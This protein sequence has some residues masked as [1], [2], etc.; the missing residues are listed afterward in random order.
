MLYSN[1]LIISSMIYL[2]L[3]LHVISINNKSKT[4]KLFLLLCLSLFWS[5]FIFS[6]AY[7]ANNKTN[8]ELLFQFASCGLFFAISTILHFYICL[9]KC[10]KLNV[11]IIF[12]IHFPAI[13]LTFISLFS[14]KLLISNLNKVNYLWE[15]QANLTSFWT[16]FFLFYLASY[17]FLS[18][19]LLII[20][21]KNTKSNKEKKQAIIG[22]SLLIVFIIGIS[23]AWILPS[24]SSYKSI[25]LTPFVSL[26]Y[27]IGIYIS[28]VKYRFL[29]I[30]PHLV[31]NEIISNVSEIILLLDQNHKIV[32]ANKSAKEVMSI[33]QNQIG[34]LH[35]NE[36][37][38][39]FEEINNK[40][41]NLLGEKIKD[42]SFY[43]CLIDN[44]QEKILINTKFSLIKDKFKDILGVLCFGY[45]VK[46]LHRFKKVYHVTDREVSVIQQI[47]NG[48][49]NKETAEILD[50]S[51]STIKSHITNIYNKLWI[52]NKIQL[53]N[54]LKEYDLL[55]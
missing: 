29:T 12:L 35:F 30:T 11:L 10:F 6:F 13:V 40:L 49:T 48:S 19:T 5:Y 42:F 34:S 43:I 2:G 51:E 8:A 23:E 3:G 54:L 17:I 50:V 27:L 1:L 31:S 55:N 16:Y 52:Y 24:F 46:E 15:V 9:T 53:N 21:K 22:I 45:V 41:N 33:N 18:M 7:P 44:K 36:I 25:G 14:K 26:I 47:I 4:N 32:F 39:G 20:W 37:T 38:E 28:I